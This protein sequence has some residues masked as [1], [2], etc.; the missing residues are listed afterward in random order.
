M[1]FSSSMNGEQLKK[2][3]RHFILRSGGI[4]R[5]K[6][7]RMAIVFDDRMREACKL[8]M[9]TEEIF[10]SVIRSRACGGATSRTVSGSSQLLRLT[11]PAALWTLDTITDPSEQI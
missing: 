7:S 2:S 10:L 8:G 4:A 5:R 6:D 1:S 9:T 3:R 11:G